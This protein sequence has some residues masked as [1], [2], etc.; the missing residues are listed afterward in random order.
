MKRYVL[1]QWKAHKAT[2]ALIIFGFFIADLILSVGVTVSRRQF[3]YYHDGMIGNP[4]EQLVI[5][6]RMAD[7]E[8]ARSVLKTVSGFGEVQVLN[9]DA[10]P[11][12]TGDAEKMITPVPVWFEQEED[13]HIPII[14]GR[15]LSAASPPDSV[16][17]FTI[18][19]IPMP[20][21]GAFSRISFA[22]SKERTVP[23][24][25]IEEAASASF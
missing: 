14:K 21:K 20:P 11:A 13:W 2:V 25:P 9:S 7:G 3:E 6:F 22:S 10:V 4:D 15:Y 18:L 12:G 16:F 19:G 5:N 1:T 17:S 8:K 24:S 23:K